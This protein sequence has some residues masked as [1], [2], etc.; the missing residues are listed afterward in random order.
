MGVM[1]QT[2]KELL[3]R[4]GEVK[5]KPLPFPRLQDFARAGLENNVSAVYKSLGGVLTR[6]EL[7]RRGSW[8]LEFDGVAVELDESRHFNR[9]RAITLQ[10]PEYTRLPKFPLDL[11]REYCHRFESECLRTGGYGGYWTNPNC[12]R[13]FGPGSAAKVLQGAGAP[14]WR[15][16]AF[17]DFI[18]DVS[19]LVLDVK[20]A[21][22]AIWDEIIDGG[23]TGTV[24]DLLSRPTIGSSKAL[25]ELVRAR[26]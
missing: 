24:R 21:R 3:A 13:Q 9:Y 17:Y 25:A 8:D 2:I 23:T 6:A 16:R 10:A 26:I 5:P 20:V 1:E 14:R 19:P 15:Q 12:E 11:Y 7:N 18:K 4:E 22:V